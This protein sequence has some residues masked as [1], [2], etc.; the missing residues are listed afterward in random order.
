MFELLSGFHRVAIA[1]QAVEAY[2][3]KAVFVYNFAHFV[4][5]WNGVKI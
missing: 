3:L 5:F 4:T 1:F 2:Q